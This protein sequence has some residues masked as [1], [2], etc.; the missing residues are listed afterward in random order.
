MIRRV[1]SGGD[2]FLRE[3]LNACIDWINSFR[4]V[5]PGVVSHIANSYGIGVTKRGDTF[6]SQELRFWA[7]ITGYTQDGSNLRWT[8]SFSEVE[9]TAAGYSV[10]ALV[11][12]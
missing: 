4:L 11:G 5:G 9:K 2:P 3:Q 12:L 7:M 6:V 1:V 8:Y 10:G